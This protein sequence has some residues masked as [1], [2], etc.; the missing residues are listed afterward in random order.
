MKTDRIYQVM[1]VDEGNVENVEEELRSLTKKKE[2]EDYMKVEK[3][4]FPTTAIDFFF[5]ENN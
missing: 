3:Y 4:L 5:A 1:E 2:N